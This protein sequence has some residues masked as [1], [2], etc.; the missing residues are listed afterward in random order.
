MVA[1]DSSRIGEKARSA[2]VG[3]VRRIW[4]R[5]ARPTGLELDL[6]VRLVD[7]GGDHAI[8]ECGGHDLATARQPFDDHMNVPGRGLDPVLSEPFGGAGLFTRV[9]AAALGIAL[10]GLHFEATTDPTSPRSSA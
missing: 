6:V 1:P 5:S 3:V 9:G 4:S 2:L 10:A 7:P 8:A